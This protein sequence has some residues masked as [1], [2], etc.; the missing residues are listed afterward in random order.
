MLHDRT[1]LSW[2]SCGSVAVTMKLAG[3]PTLYFCNINV[4]YQ[5]R[6]AGAVQGF[7]CQECHAIL[8]CGDADCI[9]GC[10]ESDA[11][12]VFLSFCTHLVSWCFEWEFWVHIKQ[13]NGQKTGHIS[14]CVH[15]SAVFYVSPE[16]GDYLVWGKSTKA[17]KIM[18][19]CGDWTGNATKWI[20]VK[21]QMNLLSK[22]L[23]S[24]CRGSLVLT[25]VCTSLRPLGWS[26]FG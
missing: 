8:R 9:A 15:H 2:L 26:T 14:N 12:H 3:T 25:L 22:Y 1:W 5:K 4:S 11:T 20:F 17:E 10:T 24:P 19:D 23:V 18:N 21:W 6:R 13:L 7:A 16:F